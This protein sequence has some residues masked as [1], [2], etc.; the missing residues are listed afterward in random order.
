MLLENKW[1]VLK[2]WKGNVKQ[3][4]GSCRLQYINFFFFFLKTGVKTLPLVI[5]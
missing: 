1:L 3:R 2:G 4:E 5:A